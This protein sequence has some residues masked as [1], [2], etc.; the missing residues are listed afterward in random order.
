MRKYLFPTL[1]LSAVAALI[2][3]IVR[4]SD[5]P[6]PTPP[7]EPKEEPEQA[8]EPEE[9]WT[10][11]TR[12]TKI[13]LRTHKWLSEL[14]RSLGRKDLSNARYYRQQVCSDIENIMADE[15]LSA[16]LLEMIKAQGADSDDP[17]KR[18]VLLKILRVFTTPEATALVE[19]QFY[20]ALDDEERIL[21]LDAMSRPDHDPNKASLWAVDMALTSESAEIRDKVLELIV[22]NTNDSRV[23][24]NT[25]IQIHQG[26][27]RLDQRLKALRAI[28]DR[29]YDPVAREFLR[30]QMANP[31]AAEVTEATGNILNWGE[32]QDLATLEQL[33]EEF[34]SHREHLMNQARDLRRELLGRKGIVEEEKEPH[35]PEDAPPL[36]EDEESMPPGEPEDG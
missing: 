11:Q 21:M 23:I 35:I 6:R 9:D 36:E 30:E 34:P 32:E 15:K 33:A 29:G 8:P 1:I 24:A 10:K 31:N 7:P 2:I 4:M 26:S 12:K 19:E 25:G 17:G 14:E 28:A 5:E 22:W 18:D 3:V 16:A 13:G 20:K 27:T